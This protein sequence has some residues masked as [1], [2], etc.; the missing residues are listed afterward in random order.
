MTRYA[1]SHG[2]QKN[3]KG[4]SCGLDFW[5]SQ[6]FSPYP[7]LLSSQTNQEQDPKTLALPGDKKFGKLNAISIPG[8][9]IE[10]HT[11]SKWQ[12]HILQCRK[13]E[14]LQEDY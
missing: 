1:T 7:L 4:N 2:S 8:V 12:E 9:D 5:I 11:L 13:T 6:E 3:R 14:T 10:I